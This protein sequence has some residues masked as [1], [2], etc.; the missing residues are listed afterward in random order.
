[1]LELFRNVVTIMWMHVLV[2]MGLILDEILYK[3][4]PGQL[5]IA[6]LAQ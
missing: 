2:K 4:Q 6:D 1:M 5:E 3:L